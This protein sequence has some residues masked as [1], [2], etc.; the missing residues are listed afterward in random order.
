VSAAPP[1]PPPAARAGGAARPLSPAAGWLLAGLVALGVLALLALGVWQLD[2]LRQRRAESLVL[3]ARLAQPP[4]DLNLSQ[5]ESLPAYTPVRAR[6]V[7]DFEHE[8]VLRNRAHRDMPG[9][10]VLTP[11]RLAGSGQVVLVDRGWIPYTQAEPAA[12]AAFQAPTGEVAI[13]GVAQP[14][15]AR[16]APFLPADPT[17]AP[18][19][20]LDAW[21]WVNLDQ[22][23]RQLPYPL[24]PYFVEAGLGADPAALPLGGSEVD[25]SD[26]P[27]LSYAIQWFAFAGILGIGSLV[28]WRQRR[29]RPG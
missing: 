9:V 17:P 3:A 15:Q 22:I 2:R 12:R 16:A 18:G 20:R 11:L 19:Q 24:L 8:I 23:A 6:G 13:E 10:H 4:L 28:L 5:P 21:F 7:Y 26:G 25:L 27:H 29:R 14:A 1:P